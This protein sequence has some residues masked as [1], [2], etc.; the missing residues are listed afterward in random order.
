MYTN[1]DLVYYN[2]LIFQF[3]FELYMILAK[4]TV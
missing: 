1:T 4:L 2:I 3:L